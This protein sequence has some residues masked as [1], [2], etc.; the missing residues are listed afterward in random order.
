MERFVGDLFSPIF[1]GPT[2]SGD[3]DKVRSSHVQ[4]HKSKI[5]GGPTASGDKDKVRC[6]TFSIYTQS[7]TKVQSLVD[8][9]PAV[10]R[11][12]SLKVRNYSV[13]S[14]QA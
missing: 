8:Q 11:I 13:Q 3:K 5:V 6:F 7:K 9:L 2:A 10:T 12:L 14:L 4:F 1:G